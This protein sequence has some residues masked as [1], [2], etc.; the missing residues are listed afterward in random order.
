MIASK[1][2]S[3]I[4]C[5][6]CKQNFR[7]RNGMMKHRKQ[8]HEEVVPDCREYLKGTCEFVGQD[9]VCLFKHSEIQ[10]FQKVPDNLAPPAQK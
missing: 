10:D 4:E 3:D 6:V 5:Y 1:E 9:K 7:T 8:Y 2:K